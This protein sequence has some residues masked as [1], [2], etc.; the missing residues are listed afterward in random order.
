MHC[1]FKFFE[2]SQPGNQKKKGYRI[3]Q[4]DFWDL[5]KKKT[6][7]HILTKNNLKVARFRQCVPVARQN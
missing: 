5:K 7:L 2:F 3:Q 4:R 1:S 6:I